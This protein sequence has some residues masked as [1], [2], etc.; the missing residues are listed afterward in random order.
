[1]PLPYQNVWEADFTA[2][3]TPGEYRLLVPGL[4]TSFPFVIDEGVAAAFARTYALGLYHQRRRTSNALPFTRF[5]H[6]P[7]HFAPAGVRGP[8]CPRAEELLAGESA[9]SADNS[10]Q[11]APQLK[12]FESSLYPFVKQGKVDVSGGH[13]DA[14]DYSKYTINSAAL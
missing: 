11:T 9:N 12:T 10:R 2:F 7:C 3:K 8:E 5:V 6:G 1:L 13:H 4:G 14:G